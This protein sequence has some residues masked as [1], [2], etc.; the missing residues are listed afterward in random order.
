[1]TATTDFTTL[2]APGL[3]PPAQPYN[4]FPKYTFV[5]GHND[6]ERVPVEALTQAV[7]DVLRRE[8]ATLAMYAR[9]N[10]S[11][12]A[13]DVGPRPVLRAALGFRA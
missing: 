1:M 3:P 11:R 13:M 12:H 4:G 7:T 5:G 10:I 9:P 2:Y 6:A 8:G